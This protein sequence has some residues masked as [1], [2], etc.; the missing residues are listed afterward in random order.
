[1]VGAPKATTDERRLLNTSFRAQFCG[2][3]DLKNAVKYRLHKRVLRSNDPH[4]RA[5]LLIGPPHPAADFAYTRLAVGCGGQPHGPVASCALL[6][7]TPSLRPCG[8]TVATARPQT[9]PLA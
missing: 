2:R 1:M 3:E 5:G 9:P 8:I 7:R 4:S 6:A